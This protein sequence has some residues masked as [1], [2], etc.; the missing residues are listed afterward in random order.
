M[1]FRRLN[2][3]YPENVLSTVKNG[4]AA[5]L[6][7]GAAVVFSPT[8]LDGYTVDQ[9]TT[10]ALSLLAGILAT[11]LA[12][13]GWGQVCIYGFRGPCATIAGHVNMYGALV[14][15][16]SGGG[17]DIAVGDIL[18]PTNGQNYLSR[19][20]AGDGKTGLV[21]A[22]AT[23]AKGTQSAVEKAVFVRCM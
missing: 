14:Q 16:D 1:Q 3:A 17:N 12:I 7:V 23:Y 5:A 19:S 11:P 10:A 9:P 15:N 13:G 4:N 2:Q 18:V 6:P 22:M 21:M 20:A 8:V